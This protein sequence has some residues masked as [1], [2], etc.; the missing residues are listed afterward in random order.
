[1]M[2]SLILLL[3][4]WGKMRLRDR[5]LFAKVIQQRRRIELNPLGSR[6]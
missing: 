2:L 6:F 1:M 3:Y 5:R 4:R